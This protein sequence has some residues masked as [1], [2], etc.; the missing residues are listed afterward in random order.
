MKEVEN[1]NIEQTLT[2]TIKEGF[3]IFIITSHKL[4]LCETPI[5]FVKAL[6]EIADY[7]PIVIVKGQLAT[8]HAEMARYD[9]IN[10]IWA[11]NSQ[12][13]YDN[14]LAQNKL[15]KTIE[16]MPSTLPD[17]SRG[18]IA[19]SSIDIAEDSSERILQ[20]LNDKSKGID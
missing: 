9:M 3:G 13:I 11:L 6:Q 17:W 14:I 12:E 10:S 2:P 16:I 1:N 20:P 4:I 19:I 7:E 18:T 5:E 8:L 15:T